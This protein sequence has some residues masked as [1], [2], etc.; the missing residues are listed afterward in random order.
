MEF[1]VLIQNGTVIDGTGSQGYQADIGIVGDV[2]QAIGNLQG[3][4]AKKTID[5]TGKVVCPGFIDVHVH[6]EL[7]VLDGPD[8]YAPLKMGV[9][10]QL[11]SP[12]GFSWAPLTG[13]K[14]REMQQYLSIF[15]T[16]QT[17]REHTEMSIADLLAVS[18]GNLPSNIVLQVPHGP[19]RLQVVGWD[20]RPATDEEIG[21]MQRLVREWMEAG[22]VAFATGLEYEPMRSSDVRELAGLSKIVAEYGG[23]Y[24][25]HQR[26]YAE[27]VKTG[28]SETIAVAKEANIPV[29]ISHFTVDEDAAA[30]VQQGLQD[31]AEITF[32]M[33]PYAAGSSHLLKNLP[34]F[35]QVGPPENVLTRLKDPKYRA[36][37]SEYLESHVAPEL[38]HFAAVGEGAPSWE[39]KSLKDVQEEMG[40][41]L[42]NAISE[43]LIQSNLQALMI[44]HWPEH[45][46]HFLEDTFKHPLHMVSTDGIYIGKRPHPRGFGTYPR[47]LRE[48]V[49]K[50]QWL[51]MEQAIYKMTGFPAKRFNIKGR[52]VLGSNQYADVVV[53][54]PQTIADKATFEQP[55]QDP[56]GIEHVFVNGHHVI[57][58][59][60]V[61]PGNPGRIQR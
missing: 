18:E 57:E 58:K 6:S 12:D 38:I 53:F 61:H 37:M 46:V 11:A 28:S 1:D 2:I 24:V 42:T 44:M 55:R 56:V 39:G 13:N 54:D 14:F 4:Q 60:Q 51:T 16:D 27:R 34:D 35:M 29:H 3:S 45:R 52:G 21:Q 5:A 17:I 36:M 15:Y 41:D 33:Y 43:V 40:L 19:V 31:G 7:A 47:V 22:A 59:G 23:V 20:D 50:N 9:T 25:A 48:Y 32:D 49:L 30:M 26:G 8:K 10:T